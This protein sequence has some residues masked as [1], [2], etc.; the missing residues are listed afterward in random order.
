MKVDVILEKA[1]SNWSAYAPDLDDVVVATGATRDETIANFR[2]AL[3]GLLSV[4]QDEGQTAPA[5]TELEVRETV[6]V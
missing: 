6:A 1:G 5:I 2:A 4:K 3:V